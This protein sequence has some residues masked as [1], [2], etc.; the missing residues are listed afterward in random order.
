MMKRILDIV[1]RFKR[2]PSVEADDKKPKGWL[3]DEEDQ[4]TPARELWQNPD[5]PISHYY[6]WIW[7]YLA[8]LP[9]LCGIVRES[10]ILEIGCSHGRTSRGLLHMIRSPGS[11][12]GFDVDRVQIEEATK[13]ITS[14]APNFQ[15]LLA[16]IF[17]RQYNPG[18]KLCSEDF[19]FPFGDSAFDCVYAA[20]VFT[21]LLPEEAANY[22]RQTG[23]VL[24]EKGMALFSFFVLDYYSGP[25]TTISPNYEFNH[26]YGED[27]EVAVRDPEY[28]DVVIAYSEKRIREYAGQAGLRVT[29]IV[30]GLW[31][32]SPGT[33]VNEQDLVVLTH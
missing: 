19:V 2:P 1:H 7:E 33:A 31:S 15:Y 3:N 24:K 5:E 13:R 28:P 9:L 14:M 10:K 20:S 6:R 32:N 12:S 30:R 18:G 17:S 11:Y 21:H 26:I 4:L 23:R 25:G 29:R 27:M 22:F 8:Y 16:D